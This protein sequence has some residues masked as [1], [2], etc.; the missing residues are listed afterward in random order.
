MA[1]A[2]PWRRCSACKKPIAL[3]VIYWYFREIPKLTD[4]VGVAEAEK[5][6]AA[7]FAEQG[8]GAAH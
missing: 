3:D 5:A 1:E 4:E 7:A 8:A 2:T 6:A